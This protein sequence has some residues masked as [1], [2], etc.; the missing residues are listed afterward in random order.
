M[1]SCLNTNPFSLK[2]YAWSEYS[3]Y[4]Y[5]KSERIIIAQV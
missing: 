4:F 2:Y 5:V 3:D 1:A